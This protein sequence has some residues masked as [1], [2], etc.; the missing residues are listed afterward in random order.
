MADS[1]IIVSLHLV[2]PFISMIQPS[3]VI[4]KKLVI[5]IQHM[6][7]MPN[8]GPILSSIN[9]FLPFNFFLLKLVGVGHFVHIFILGRWN[10]N[11]MSKW[12]VFS[13]KS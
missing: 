10:P 1:D 8:S 12:D 13:S 4:T 2:I 11:F 6:I 5:T 3:T 7:A 9:Y